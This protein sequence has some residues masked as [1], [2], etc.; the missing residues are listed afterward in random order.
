[1]SLVFRSLLP[2]L[3]A[4]AVL[5]GT[6]DA[7]P[8]QS[9]KDAWVATNDQLLTLE[10]GQLVGKDVDLDNP[11]SRAFKAL[12]FER[13]Q[14]GTTAL[15]VRGLIAVDDTEVW[16]FETNTPDVPPRLLFD[17]ATTAPA[18]RYVTAVAV[19]DDDHILISGYSRPKRVYEIWEVEIPPSGP[20]IFW[21]RASSTPQITDTVYVRPED[22]TGGPLAVGGLLA[23]AGKQVLFFPKVSNPPAPPFTTVVVLADAKSLALKGATDLTSVDLVKRT[24][25]LMIATTERTLLTRRADLSR[26]I[27]SWNSFATV[28][29]PSAPVPVANCRTLRTQ[30]LIVRSAQGGTDT[31]T[32]VADSACQQLVRYD[33]AS[34]ELTTTNNTADDDATWSAPLAALAV[35]E[36]NTVTCEPSQSPNDFCE[37]ISG[38]ALDARINTSETTQLLVLQFPDLCDGRVNPACPVIPVSAGSLRLNGLLP[39]AF[40][41]A[42]GTAEITIPSYMSAARGDGRFGVVFVQ[43]DDAGDD[44]GA[45]LH[46]E[47]QELIGHEL[48]V[49]ENLPRLSAANPIR[50]LNQDVA[51]YAPDNPDLPTVRGFESTPI[52]TGRGSMEADMRGFSAIIYGLQHD[53]YPPSPRTA[54]IGIPTGT[55]LGGS[56]PGVGCDLVLGSQSYD[57]DETATNKYFLNLIACLF[58]DEEKL[59]KDVIPGDYPALEVSLNQVKDK[60]IKALSGAGP[61]TGSETFGAVLSQL[62]NFDAAVAATPFTGLKIYKNE[63][64]VRSKVFR[65]NVKERAIPSIPTGGF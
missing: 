10:A 64:L 32:F 4:A 41:A 18:L 12:A 40:Q 21:P 17:A 56:T 52:T 63:L 50:V 46:L 49:A 65:F 23:T 30:R 43:A 61:N 35:G 59:L 5:V 20:P 58:A 37:L 25:T 31:S 1:M 47:I 45:F 57:P 36:G 27:V 38:N 62:D 6:A 13:P 19:T 9:L 28:G 2:G 53:V 14:L 22:V 51:A 8:I 39:P 34:S 44:A 16:R 55:T 33:V 11:P 3:T 48:G 26:D 7:Q 60:L 54:T 42:L 15:E 24:G 29:L